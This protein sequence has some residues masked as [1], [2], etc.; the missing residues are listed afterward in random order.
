MIETSSPFSA[1]GAYLVDCVLLVSVRHDD[2]VVLGPH[3]ALHPLPVS[4][5]ALVDVPT[6]GVSPYKRSA[7]ASQYYG[8]GEKSGQLI[9]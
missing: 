8:G 7:R 9:R 6:R 3:V 5:A 2:P 1:D 4:R